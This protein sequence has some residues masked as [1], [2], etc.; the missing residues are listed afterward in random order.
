MLPGREL[1]FVSFPEG[2]QG[3]DLLLGE[4]RERPWDKGMFSLWDDRAL[5]CRF[6]RCCMYSYDH[7]GKRACDVEWFVDGHDHN[8]RC[9]KRLCFNSIQLIQC[10]IRFDKST[11]FRI[12]CRIAGSSNGRTSASGAE[13]LGSSP[14]PAANVERATI[15]GTPGFAF[16]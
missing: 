15:Y 7:S 16:L 1:H 12:I 8:E 13:Y 10:Q 14:S 5:C 6:C 3:S 9:L 4:A 2:R 11:F